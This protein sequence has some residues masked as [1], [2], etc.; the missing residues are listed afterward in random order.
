MVSFFDR[1][2]WTSTPRPVR[3]LVDLDAKILVGLAIHYTGS[4]SPL[5][6]TA[7]LA[8]SINRL[9]A[10]RRD[11]TTASKSDPSKP[12]A[13]IAYQAA[14]S[15][16][17]DIFDCRGITYQSAANGSQESNR[18][19]GAVTFLI[20]V[21]DVPSLRAVNAFQAWYRSVWLHRWPRA[22][23]IV[24]HRDLYQTACPGDPLCSL[25]RTN[26]LSGLP[27]KEPDVT[28]ADDIGRA[29]DRAV[30]SAEAGF[31]VHAPTKADPSHLIPVVDWMARV[32]AAVEDTRDAVLR[33]E[34][35]AGTP[36]G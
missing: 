24:G 6:S 25:I 9:E 29:V 31:Q 21:G 32:L 14:I 12:W 18:K 16:S 17:G 36:P 35:A 19:Y 30:M 20:G 5:G 23:R 8:Q 7:T 22:T 28:S 4:A 26:A 34:E 11:H 13:D 3:A 15:Q 33:L 2:V 10:E 1:S 27:P